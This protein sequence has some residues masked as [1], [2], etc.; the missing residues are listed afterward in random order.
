MTSEQF[1]D[2]VATL[3]GVWPAKQDAVLSDAAMELKNA[4]WIW[5]DKKAATTAPVG[6][7]Y[8]RRSF[9]ISQP[10]ERASAVVAADNSFELLV[11]GKKV[12]SGD[13]WN[14]PVKVELTPHLHQGTNVLA[15]I[16]ENGAK[17]P[18]PAGLV[19]R[20]DFRYRRPIAGKPLRAL[21][22]D[23][24]WR[25]LRR[26]A[27][28][29][30]GGPPPISTTNRGRRRRCWATSPSGRGRWRKRSAPLPMTRTARSIRLRKSGRR[31]AR[32][33]R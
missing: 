19:V 22:S 33:P 26:V 2:A 7:A 17:E 27:R 16:A 13:D 15:V 3:T 5:N 32:P 1:A 9:Q 24:N 29:R 23:A 30:T 12:A 18:N 4:R 11:N 21:A 25:A 10:L 28:Y 14:K 8:F 31:C 20:A 6:K